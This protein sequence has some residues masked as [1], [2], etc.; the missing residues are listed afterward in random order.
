M[1]NFV[2]GLDGGGTKTDGVLVGQDGRVLARRCVGAS[3]PNDVGEEASAAVVRALVEVL[4]TEAGVPLADCFVFGGISGALNHREG[5][6]ARLRSAVPAPG[7]VEIDSDMVNLLSAELPD[8]DGACIIC[9]T[10]SACFVRRGQEVF[11]IGGW[12]YLLAAL[13]NMGGILLWLVLQYGTLFRTGVAFYPGQ[14]LGGILLFALV[15][16]LAIASCL[17][18][19][20]YK[21]TGSVY[22]AAFLNTILMTMM[23]VANTAIYFQA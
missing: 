12:G 20:L 18:K 3:N 19:Y 9:G 14:A 1:H 11:R 13:T 21:K 7:G 4:A 23:T 5:L 22:V 15:P 10:G 8:R 2:I 16:S 6:T 17:A